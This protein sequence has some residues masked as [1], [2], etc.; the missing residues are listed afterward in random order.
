[1]C[2][3]FN[4]KNKQIFKDTFKY[5]LFID[6]RYT[7]AYLFLLSDSQTYMSSALYLRKLKTCT[8]FLCYARTKRTTKWNSFL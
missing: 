7:I 8:S 6:D 3:N 2:K 1:M 4:R 5:D